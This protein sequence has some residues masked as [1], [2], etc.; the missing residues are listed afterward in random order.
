MSRREGRACVVRLSAHAAYPWSSEARVGEWS[1]FARGYAWRGTRHYS[2][3]E[4]AREAASRASSGEAVDFVSELNGAFCMV[5]TRSG[6][7]FA[8]V[9][10][11]R[12]LPLFYGASGDTLV[13]A[14]DPLAVLPE[15]R[16]LSFAEDSMVEF[17]RCG[18]ALGNR[19]LLAGV[20]QLQA[21]QY[22]V[23]SA[24]EFHVAR[25]YYQHLH[26]PWTN[27]SR[28]DALDWLASVSSRAFDRFIDQ[29]DGRTC[30]VPLSGGYDSRFIVAMLR[31][32]GYEDVVC[33]T[34]G[35]RNSQEVT[36]ARLTA[37]RLGY[38]WHYVR[39]DAATW[40]GL[41]ESRDAAAY[42]TSCGAYAALPHIQEYPAVLWLTEHD[43][44]PESAVFAPGF[45]GD[46]LGGSYVPELPIP[47]QDS[48]LLEAG[49]A[50]YVYESHTVLKTRLSSDLERRLQRRVAETLQEY[51]QPTTFEEFVSVNEAWFT[52]HKVARFVVNS[53]RVYEHFGYEWLMP[54]WDNELAE[55]WYRV[56]L[57]LRVGSRLYENLLF[58][59]LF[60]PL[61]IAFEK[62][63]QLH[64]RWPA[65]TVQAVLPGQWYSHL[66]SRYG[67][68][69]MRLRP[70]N[71]NAFME[72]ADL[73]RAYGRARGLRIPWSSDINQV[74]APVI[75][76]RMCDE[77]GSGTEFTRLYRG[78]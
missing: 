16:P 59:W 30:I 57:Q 32:A 60:R 12:S 74:I 27:H 21:G 22:L 35:A 9:D 37:E 62:P 14:D 47:N 10:R 72:L 42:L 8:A 75:L 3:I 51:P 25:F 70:P 48:A 13:V 18:Y 19:T 61:D 64:D 78:A 39:Y 50:R 58:T 65:S 11:V 76:A 41:W 54:L 67:V 40:R 53:L 66:R 26:E 77:V 4:L 17:L 15:T 36:P 6:A 7:A 45:C 23:Q 20:S 2:S 68:I 29:L 28:E 1:G 73:T 43:L 33:Y 44:L 46:L 52:A 5:A 63:R 56:P 69:K 55:A 31:R 24:E 71:P 34:Y 38:P 49:I